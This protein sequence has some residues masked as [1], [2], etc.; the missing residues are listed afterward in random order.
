MKL[1]HQNWKIE[2]KKNIVW[3]ENVWGFPYRLLSMHQ[4]IVWSDLFQFSL[5]QG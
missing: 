5:Q 3:S 2:R 4:H 1:D